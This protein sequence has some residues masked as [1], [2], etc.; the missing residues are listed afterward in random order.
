M[1]EIQK[2]K[3][4]TNLLRVFK[5]PEVKSSLKLSTFPKKQSVETGTESNVSL[6]TPAKESQQ[7]LIHLKLR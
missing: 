3:R 6:I 2:K 4:K 1:S 5:H 7:N